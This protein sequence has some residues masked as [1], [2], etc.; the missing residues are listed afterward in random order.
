MENTTVT[1]T[2]T[3]GPLIC[4]I[5]GHLNHAERRR[6]LLGHDFVVVRSLEDGRHIVDIAHVHR[7]QRAVLI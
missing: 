1:T 2:T 5:Y 7:N 4:M 6:T 3:T